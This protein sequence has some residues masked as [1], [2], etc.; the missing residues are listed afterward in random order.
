MR[1]TIRFM[2]PIEP[3]TKKNYQTISVNPNT[4]KHFVT[5]SL[6]YKKYREDVGYFFERKKG[7]DKLPCKY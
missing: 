1:K 3:K 5:P 7:E 6:Q 2:I 4:G